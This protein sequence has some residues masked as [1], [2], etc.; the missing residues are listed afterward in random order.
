MNRTHKN[1]ICNKSQKICKQI[2]LKI[3]ILDVLLYIHI[4]LFNGLYALEVWQAD[5]AGKQF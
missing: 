1:K 3:L 2:V 4:N 5:F